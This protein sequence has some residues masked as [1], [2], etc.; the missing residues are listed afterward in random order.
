LSGI[1]LVFIITGFSA[2]AQ[3]SILAISYFYIYVCF[4]CMGFEPAIEYNE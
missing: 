3:Y 4:L 2:L 1:G